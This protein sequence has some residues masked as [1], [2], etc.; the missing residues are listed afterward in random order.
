LRIVAH[1][2]N[3]KWRQKRIFDYECDI[4]V[5]EL[6]YFFKIVLSELKMALI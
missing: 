4:I 1:V 5:G 3:Y 2:L 6:C